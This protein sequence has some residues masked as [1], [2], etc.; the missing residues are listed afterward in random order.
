[1]FKRV[2]ALFEAR[3][4]VW[5]FTLREL[6]TRYRR[7][8]FGWLWSLATP[9]T[10][11]IIYSYVF[12]TLLKT[13]A[14]PG[15]PSGITTFGLFLLSGLIPF[16]FFSSATGAGINALVE[17]ADLI[18]KVAFPRESLIL[19]KILNAAVQFC[20]EIFLLVIVFLIAGSPL[21]PWL[22]ETLLLVLLFTIF[23]TGVSLLLSVGTVYLRDIPHFWGIFIQI[24]FFA[25]P[26]VYPPS[27]LEQH[28]QGPL[29]LILDLNPINHFVEAFR[30][31]LYDGK[32][33][34]FGSL[35]ILVGISF[36]SLVIGWVLFGRF[37]HS[38]AEDL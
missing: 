3:Q 16:G 8:L 32:G 33:V 29:K 24:W 19:A 12:G 38:V 13:N 1:M 22:P 4:L 18:R 21:L 30:T 35:L 15:D 23:T 27:L 17:S 11:L 20:I 14:P 2:N 37:T 25:T 6:R 34:S 7:T 9:L 31:T 26:I 36:G 5:N 28:V 10:S